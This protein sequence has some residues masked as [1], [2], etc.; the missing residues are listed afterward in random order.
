MIY[1]QFNTYTSVRQNQ[2]T[3]LVYSSIEAMGKNKHGVAGSPIISRQSNKYSNF[4][5]ELIR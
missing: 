5:L 4:Q 3:F 1:S 2:Y